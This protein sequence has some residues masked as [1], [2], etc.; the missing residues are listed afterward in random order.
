MLHL[1]P[2]QMRLHL[3][4]QIDLILTFLQIQILLEILNKTLAQTLPRKGPRC[5]LYYFLQQLFS[6][7]LHLPILR[8]VQGWKPIDGHHCRRPTLKK[9]QYRF[10]RSPSCYF[11]SSSRQNKVIAEAFERHQLPP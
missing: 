7:R 11:L 6:N 5:H 8:F 4:H 9:R 2:I 3:L 10:G 1:R